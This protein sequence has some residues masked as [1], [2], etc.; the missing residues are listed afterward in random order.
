M[1][2]DVM[3]VPAFWDADD[4]V[5]RGLDGLEVTGREHFPCCPVQAQAQPVLDV[6]PCIASCRIPDEP[7]C[8]RLPVLCSDGILVRLE[9]A[10]PAMAPGRGELL[11]RPTLPAIA[12]APVAELIGQL[13][14]GAE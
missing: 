10:Q 12:G 9:G 8:S 2:G 1:T 6:H 3:A 13:Q 5:A 7:T 11:C 4:P 14:H